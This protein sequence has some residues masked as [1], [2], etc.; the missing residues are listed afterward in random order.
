MQSDRKG[1]WQLMASTAITM[2]IGLPQIASAQSAET[3]TPSLDE[4]VVTADTL[5]TKAVQVG[6]F[7]G[8]KQLDTPLTISV[9]SRDTLD[10]QQARSI[11]D[12]LRNTPGVTPA[13]TS[14]IVYNSL[15]I[16]GIAVENRGNYRLDGTLPIINLTD[17][18]LE[19]KERVEALKGASALYYGFTTPSGIINLTMKRPTANPMLTAEVFGN[20]HGQAGA[21]VDAGNTSGIFGYRING[22]YDTPDVGIDHTAGVRTLLSAAIDIKPTDALTIELDGER[23]Y[24]RLNEP[25]SYGFR[26]LPTS[27]VANPYPT[28]ALPNLI[29][30][31]TNLGPDWA[32]NRTKASNLLAKA[33]YKLSP[34]WQL[35]ASAG[36]ARLTRERHFNNIDPN[37]PN[38]NPLTGPLGEYPLSISYQPVS[39]FRN[40]NFRGEVAGAFDTGPLRHEILI[41]ASSNS[42]SNKSAAQNNEA[43]L[44]NSTTGAFL[45][46]TFLATAPAG[47][48]RVTCRENIPNPHGVP[49]LPEPLNILNAPAEIKDVGAYVFD[50][51]KYGEWLQIL[52]GV[53]SSNYQEKRLDTGVKTFTA[54]PTS[55]SG[56]VVIKPVK[57]VS[58]YAT[59]IE[60]LESTPNPPPTVTN[61]NEQLGPSASTQYEAG[62]KWEIL[63]TLL[64]QSAYFDIKRDSAVINGSNTYVKDGQQTYR[65]AE[66]SLTGSVT[67][68]LTIYASALFLDAKYSS[69]S[70]TILLTNANGTPR[71]DAASGSQIVSPTIVGKRVEGSPKVSWSISG[72]Y[73]LGALVE[74]LAVTA[75]VYHVGNQPIN[76]LNQNFVP[77]YTLLD[78]GASYRTEV[79]EHPVTLRIYGTNVTNKKYF[80]STGGLFAVQGG[81][82][83]V[84]FSLSTSF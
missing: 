58:V 1:R 55:L 18:P 76:P 47:Q 24:K 71:I 9:I 44:Y 51:I 84:K 10:V 6:S 32:F 28:I 11:F 57:T 48:T 38:T 23:L 34:S 54:K 3:S 67:H 75:G 56:G 62:V 16:R 2:A 83:V 33:V 61:P 19:D 49:L 79:G 66:F 65:G 40:E 52:G 81:P 50:R 80:A 63:P 64:F 22:V 73:R 59:Y 78:L 45:G 26:K 77:A 21:H 37:D 29:D 15:A 70:P 82:P 60:G 14:P 42:R 74:G 68:D 72:E 30:P 7:R 20:N 41:G 17:L 39:S 5:G 31:S 13:Q 27:T 4:V 46:A 36:L 25:A 43:C 35:I 53:R 12:A 8:A 69:G